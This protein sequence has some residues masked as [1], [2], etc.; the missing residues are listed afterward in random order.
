MN[1]AKLC[2]R[3]GVERKTGQEMQT[4]THTHTQTHTHKHT[5][6][7]T[8]T[9]TQGEREKGMEY[10]YVC[11]CVCICDKS[12]CLHTLLSIGVLVQPDHFVYHIL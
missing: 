7:H 4:C 12:A 8:H 1:K 10:M 11:V 2:T 5:H 9:H 3:R 6:T